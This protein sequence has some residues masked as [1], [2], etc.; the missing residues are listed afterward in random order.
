MTTRRWLLLLLVVV[1]S[2]LAVGAAVWCAGAKQDEKVTLDQVP[3][4]VK[5]T[6]V[7]AAEGGKIEAIERETKDAR[8]V[9]EAELAI[10]GKTFGVRVAPDGKL[11]SRAV[12][13]E[14]EGDK[15]EEGG[16][17]LTLDQVPAA[18]KATIVKAAEGG[19]IGGIEQATED[20]KTVYEAEVTIGAKT[21]DVKVAPDGKLL[22][23]EADEDDGD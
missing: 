7:K 21:F 11:L 10:D 3:A 16:K 13:D 15:A 17:T 4:A 2:V 22:S 1:A 5:V 6:I 9:Y 8:T 12:D 19:R 20:G 18:V 23:K 14:G